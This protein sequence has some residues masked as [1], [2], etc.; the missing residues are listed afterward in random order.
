[1][2]DPLPQKP[3]IS[4]PK[5]QCYLIRKGT[6]ITDV[7]SESLSNGKFPAKRRENPT[8]LSRMI[9]NLENL[10]SKN[11]MISRKGFQNYEIN[12]C[13]RYLMF[14]DMKKLP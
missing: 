2:Q 5:E 4:K 8:S 6:L 10:I 3:Q 7:H 13:L 1:M 9:F 11:I 12:F 14:W